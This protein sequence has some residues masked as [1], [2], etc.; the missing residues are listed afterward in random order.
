MQMK[1]CVLLMIT[2]VALST[3]LQLWSPRFLGAFVFHFRHV[4]NNAAVTRLAIAIGWEAIVVRVEAIASREAIAIRWKAIA[5][6][7]EAIAIRTEAIAIRL[8]AIAIR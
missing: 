5:N 1:S 7:W 3:E 6:R 8:V 4:S 2:C